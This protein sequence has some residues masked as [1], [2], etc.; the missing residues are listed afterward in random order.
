MLGWGWPGDNNLNSMLIQKDSIWIFKRKILK[1]MWRRKSFYL[2]FLLLQYSW[3]THI[4]QFTYKAKQWSNWKHKKGHE[5]NITNQTRSK[6]SP[7]DIFNGL[8]NM[9]NL[10]AEECFMYQRAQYSI[11]PA[12]LNRYGS[13]Q[14]QS[15]TEPLISKSQKSTKFS[16]RSL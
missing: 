9:Y 4:A 13:N 2:K 15:K 7:T 1:T 11:S 6:G 12:W 16:M 5:R 3:T 10:N 14:N 8:R